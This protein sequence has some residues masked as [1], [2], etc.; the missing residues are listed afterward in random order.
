M[1]QKII[2][3]IRSAVA[4]AKSSGGARPRYSEKI[5][6]A[7]VEACRSGVRASEVARLTGLSGATVFEWVKRNGDRF[8]AVRVSPIASESAPIYVHVPGGVRIECSSSHQL[9]EVL[10]S[11]K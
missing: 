2:A 1:D 3:K 4:A 10:E 11:L 8:R 6:V 5:K 7:V 9:R